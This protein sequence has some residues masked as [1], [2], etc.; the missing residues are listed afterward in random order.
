MAPLFWKAKAAIRGQ[1]EHDS[2]IGNRQQF[3][4]PIGQPLRPLDYVYCGTSPRRCASPC[5]CRGLRYDRPAPPFGTPSARRH[6][7]CCAAT[8]PRL[9]NDSVLAATSPSERR[10]LRGAMPPRVATHSVPGRG[11]FGKRQGPFEQSPTI[12]E[13]KLAIAAWSSISP[14]VEHSGVLGAHN[15]PASPK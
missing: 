13:S 1:R 4:L 14:L 2:E 15:A 3:G 5:N 10:S 11:D 9:R 8:L 7:Q 12:H 6:E